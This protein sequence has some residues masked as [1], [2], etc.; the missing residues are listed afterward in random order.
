[1]TNTVKRILVDIT[2]NK[3][4]KSFCHGRVVG[5]FSVLSFIAIQTIALFKG[6]ELHIQDFG[7]GLA[8]VITAVGANIMMKSKTEPGQD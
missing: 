8:A 6:Q 2:T 5:L 7:L 4:G 3:D 1:M